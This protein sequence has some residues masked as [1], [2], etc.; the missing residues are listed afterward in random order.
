MP[1]AKWWSKQ[2]SVRRG[3]C[4]VDIRVST[5]IQRTES[6]EHELRQYC[7]QR[8]WKDLVF[9]VDKIGGAKASR[10]QLDQLT[11]DIRSGKIERLLVF[12][13]DRLGRSLTPVL[14]P[15]RSLVSGHHGPD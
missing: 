11:R 5:G 15:A 13:L 4:P 1:S 6:Q 3:K 8:G 12:K 2:G 9:Y 7:R 10:P 14:V